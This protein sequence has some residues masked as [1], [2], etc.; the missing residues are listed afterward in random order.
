MLRLSFSISCFKNNFSIHKSQ[1][2]EDDEYYRRYNPS[3]SQYGIVDDSRKNE[4]HFAWSWCRKSWSEVQRHVFV[5]FGD[6]NLFWVKQGMG[7]S[8]GKGRQ[9]SK[10]KFIKK[11][12][13]DLELLETL[14]D[15]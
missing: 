1:L 12:G 13:G 5:D 14:I 3:S 2:D 10:E 11:Y 4:F 9:I 15:N 7:T 6:E 8:Y